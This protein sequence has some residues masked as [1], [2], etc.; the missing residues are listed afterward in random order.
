[1]LIPKKEATSEPTN[2]R[3]ISLVNSILNIFSK[4]LANRMQHLMGRFLTETQTTFVKERSILHDF[5]YAQ[6]VIGMT[7]KRKEQMMVFKAD[8]YKTF[9]LIE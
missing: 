8:I 7:T 9:D 3:P 4:I 2:F 5:H 6:E 1:V